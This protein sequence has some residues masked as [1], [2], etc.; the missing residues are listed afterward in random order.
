MGLLVMEACKIITDV[1]SYKLPNMVLNTAW[2][3]AMVTKACLI[4]FS[5]RTAHYTT[6][7][8]FFK[9]LSARL[10]YIRNC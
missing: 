3:I 2:K 4:S 9:V 10:I 8:P 6:Q 7:Q 5:I 1:A